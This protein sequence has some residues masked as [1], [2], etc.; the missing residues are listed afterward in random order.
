VGDKKAYRQDSDH[1]NHAETSKEPAAPILQLAPGTPAQLQA[2]AAAYQRVDRDTDA[3]ELGAAMSARNADKIL[4]VLARNVDPE[5]MC[6]LRRAYG[7]GFG[8]DLH[9]TLNAGQFAQARAYAG[10]QISLTVQLGTHDR[11]AIFR[12]LEQLSDVRAL[13]LVMTSTS[14]GVIAPV[15]T[16]SAP[17]ASTLPEVQT[18]LRTNLTTD[19]YYR[20]MRLILDKAKRAVAHDPGAGFAA[21]V[22]FTADER[23]VH[24]ESMP[25]ALLIGLGT[26][27]PIPALRVDL[28]EERLRAADGSPGTKAELDAYLRQRRPG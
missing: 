24:A 5:A 9:A 7:D 17:P 3:R 12:D 26:G 10:E 21:L 2:Q 4:A 14:A 19:E 16:K 22:G 15:E 28:A 25:Q 11:E 6:A 23:D 18:V 8:A 20:A 27:N 1:A 13:E